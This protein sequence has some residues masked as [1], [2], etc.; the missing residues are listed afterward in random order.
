M[1]YAASRSFS[2]IAACGLAVMVAPVARAADPT[3][4]SDTPA[5]P[6]Q[7]VAPDGKVE[8]VIVTAQRTRQNLQKVPV[9]DTVLS[10]KQL[11]NKQV[12]VTSDALKFVPNVIALSGSGY[13]QANYYFRGIGES[14]GF[15]TFDS[16]V[17]T[18]VDDVVLG[19]LGGANSELLDLDRVEVLRGPQGTVFGRNTTG[20]A[21]L[22]YSKKPTDDYHAKAEVAFGSHN[23][24]DSRYMV[25]MPVVPTLDMRLSAFEFRNDGFQ[26]DI[27]NGKDNYGG[28]ENWGVRGALRWR[29][30][31]DLDWNVAL[32]Y[33][34]ESGQQYGVATDPNDPA[35]WTQ[36]PGIVG[37][38]FKAVST[39]LNDCTNGGSAL[40]W[41]RNNCSGSITTNLGLTSNL[42]Y[43]V[44]PD[45]S[46]EF[47]TG[48]RQDTQSY[49]LDVGFD[50]P[51]GLLK[52]YVIPT[53]SVFEQMSQELKA[54]GNFF[55]GFI[56]YVGGLYFFREWDT[57]RIDSFLRLGTSLIATAADRTAVG[58]EKVRNGTTSEAGYLQTDTHLTSK[59]TLTTG[60]RYTHDHKEVA[61]NY[62]NGTTGALIYDTA[63]IAGQKS[64]ET[65]RFT[66]KVAISYQ[67]TPDAMVYGSYVD[68]FRS[69]GWNGRAQTAAGFT[70]FG[71]EKAQSW[72][73]GW[74]TQ[75]FDER[76]RLN[77]T[78]FWVNYNSLQLQSSYV[79]ADGEITSI[80]ANAGNSEV[81]GFELESQAV[82]T[83]DLIAN[84]SLG[85]QD[86]KFT[87]LSPGVASADGL[88]LK[89]AV[90]FS[91]PA[92]FTAGLTYHLPAPWARGDFT[93]AANL[94]WI[95]PYNTGSA[96][97]AGDTPTQDI[98]SG[99]ITYKPAD[100]N[101]WSV[102]LECTNCLFRY[103]VTN[104]SGSY[105][106]ITQPGYVGVRLR[107]DM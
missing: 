81:R 23:Q 20:G 3:S 31:A 99:A 98:V 18:Y 59:L 63:D 2:I 77:G 51:F 102:S 91:P 67:V 8:A 38:S 1:K 97:T 61:V 57:T 70:S 106:A 96:A 16:P 29:P 107:Y 14:D 22:L 76:L 25:N 105:E 68:G 17:A 24:L 6:G 73:L 53:D 41:E 89:S 15:Q 55:N 42:H 39:S 34:H 54:S 85:L 11:E 37:N 101:K 72:E 58:D 56:T 95:P 12:F 88:T 52:D 79:A 32:D 28:Q 13:A 27:D 49:S 21:V 74:R 66:P 33:S 83:D 45:L 48:I 30:N 19:R 93:V 84:V 26:K 47:I 75:L 4:N 82:I 64:I 92:T 100:F 7:A 46:L 78:F 44:T 87:E 86:A 71:D 10:A 69:G 36:K 9:T 60:L 62:N 40:D 65:Y 103:Y 90:P 94:Q 43:T 35:E 104:Q 80:F 5:P 50:N